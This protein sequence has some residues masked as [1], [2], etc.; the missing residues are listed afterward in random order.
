MRPEAA[1]ES[2]QE[3]LQGEV[4]C[5]YQRQR[6]LGAVS[7]CAWEPARWT[8]PSTPLAQAGAS[9]NQRGARIAEHSRP[10][11]DQSGT[12]EPLNQAR[13]CSSPGASQAQSATALRSSDRESLPLS[14]EQVSE[15]SVEPDCCIRARRPYSQ[16]LACLQRAACCQLV[17]THTHTH[18]HTHTHTHRCIKGK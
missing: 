17:K 15:P 10:H 13:C 3:H 4:W 8:S 5:L 11:P 9:L 2:W 6:G 1:S 16:P 18:P 7:W 14:S 12:R